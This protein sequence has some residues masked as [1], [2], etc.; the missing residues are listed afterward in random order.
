MEK[1]IDMKLNIDASRTHRELGWQPTP[2]YDILRRLLLLIENKKTYPEIWKFKNE[3]ALRHVEQRLNSIIY[4]ALVDSKET[5]ISKIL[6]YLLSPENKYRFPHY[7]QM[8]KNTLRWYVKFIYQIV[9]A[10]V[11]SGDRLLI[12]NYA[13]IIARQRYLEN[14]DSNEVGN[15]FISIGNIIAR[16][17]KNL[18][19]LNHL[20]QTI[21]DQINMTFQLAA[22]VVEDYNERLG[23]EKFL[24]NTKKA[25][26]IS[27][28]INFEKLLYELED[29]CQD[30]SEKE[31]I[32]ESTLKKG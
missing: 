3:L 5:L 32:N 22:D 27:K 19:K 11:R 13:E 18:P 12:R 21:Y 4:D 26:P 16:H 17:L 6:T 29:I 20:Q 10:I 7:Q 23:G 25:E 31:F 28:N 2:R 24:K 14:F 1:Y 15:A 9:T 30:I 8:K